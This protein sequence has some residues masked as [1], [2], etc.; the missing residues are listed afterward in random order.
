M[1]DTT[2][3]AY[4]MI[5]EDNPRN[6][7]FQKCADAYHCIYELPPELKLLPWVHKHVSQK[8]HNALA[9]S[10]RVLSTKHAKIKKIP[11]VG[12]T[13][14]KKKANEDERNLE[15]QLRNASQ[16]RS[17]RIESDFV[18]SALLYKCVGAMVI[19]IDW[20]I[21]QAKALNMDTTAMERA[22]RISRFVVNVYNPAHLHVQRSVYGVDTVLLAYRR[23]ATEVI[24]EWGKENI[25][26]EIKD[27]ADKE[28]SDTIYY[29]DLMN[30][31]TR[32]VWVQNDKESDPYWIMNETDHG[33]DFLPW[34]EELGGS[35]LEDDVAHKY[36]SMPYSVIKS[37]ALE[38]QHVMGTL[39]L[40]DAIAK[41][42]P[43]EF[44]EEGP[45]P[46]RATIDAMDPHGTIKMAA[47][48]TLKALQKS[49]ID[50]KLAEL[51]DRSS[52]DVQQSTIPDVLMGGALPSGMAFSTY[53][54]ATQTA[55]GQ[56][57]PFKELAE[58]GI[59]QV[60]RLM[61]MWVRH[62]G[63]P[64][65]AYGVQ[66]RGDLG[67]SYTINPDEIDPTALYIEAE[68]I[69]VKPTDDIAKWNAGSIANQVGLPR[70]YVLEDAGVDDPQGAL[71]LWEAEKID[72]HL[73]EKWKAKEMMALE[74]EAMAA[75]RAMEQEA[76][77]AQQAQEQPQQG[78]I[79][80]GQGF[81]VGEG[82]TPPIQANPPENQLREQVQ[83]KTRTGEP[84]A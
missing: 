29:F 53:N 59:A 42:I 7:Y 77:A 45:N 71:K 21:K 82:G 24:K 15:W 44:V 74:Q 75:Q 27:I 52:M 23:S 69:P 34:V 8:L 49:G 33:L 60:C 2:E 4:K 46:E 38:T 35:A 19:D 66:D 80:G 81:S 72:E 64:L 63:V 14:N 51:Y 37:G 36:Q 9:A 28:D 12:D 48:N 47:G 18:E 76:M 6:E 84:L 65:T 43:A 11:Y 83:G 22:R 57:K 68:L 62:T 16:L 70:E 10:R 31:E 13:A 50:P 40:T 78:M 1:T 5:R 54:L 73:L 17:D 30:H 26:Q 61:L 25:P 20:Q 58:K 56:I 41:A 55:I 79:P 32:S 3:L 39:M 67:V